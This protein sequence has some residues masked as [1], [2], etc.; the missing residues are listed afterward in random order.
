M[1]F[2]ALTN[3]THALRTR[4]AIASVLAGLAMGTAAP[5]LAQTAEM[6]ADERA[7]LEAQL[8][9][10]RAAS[11]ANPE[12]DRI[13]FTR[14]MT[15]SKL[16]YTS[17]AIRALE[18]LTSSKSGLY[19]AE[20]ELA[21]LYFKTG[22]FE[23]A[24][25]LFE[26]VGSAPTASPELKGRINEYVGAID[27]RMQTELTTGTI[28][29]GVAYQ[30]NANGGIDLAT[31]GGN[32]GGT[33][34]TVD[35]EDDFN[36]FASAAVSHVRRIGDWQRALWET[37]GQ[38]YGA[39]QFKVDEVHAIYGETM[40]GVK[41]GLGHDQL[42]SVTI[43]PY[44]RVDYLFLGEKSYNLGAGG[45]LLT[46]FRVTDDITLGAGYQYTL[47]TYFDSDERPDAEEREG[48]EHQFTGQIGF[49]LSEETT[50]TG[51]VDYIITDA[52]TDWWSSDAWEF[53]VR[54]THIFGG[55][56]EPGTLPMSIS[57]GGSYRM[58]EFDGGNMNFP[59]PF[60]TIVRDEDRYIVDATVVIPVA[61]T[62]GV[63]GGVS[64][65]NQDSN[66]FIY[67]Y[68]NL[69]VAVAAIMSF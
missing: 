55:S 21:V 22:D 16:G 40:S 51:K 4:T 60:D 48:N 52:D 26:S 41:F 11:M 34:D 62:F 68:D 10:L 23:K 58:T 54:A 49:K 67:D 7:Q 3:F 14:A 42:D 57:V 29:V 9:Q 39:F 24:K 13:A 1:R 69:R 19:R 44:V 5:A 35:E 47:E 31:G 32:S 6:S 28:A 30:T 38:L 66:F 63:T 65:L 45:G 33:L 61:D 64:Y 15:A 12:D 8:E 17:E 37:T 27:K 36:L 25:P 56:P 20:L 50:F 46:N 43:K 53:S 59:A 18:K 2:D